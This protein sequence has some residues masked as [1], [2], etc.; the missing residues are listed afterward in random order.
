MPLL[1]HFTDTLGYN[2]IQQEGQIRP[3]NRGKFGAGVYLT[4]LNPNQAETQDIAQHLYQGGAQ[5]RQHQGRLNHF[6]QVKIPANDP[7]LKYV[8]EHVYRFGNGEQAL[9]LGLYEVQS[10]GPCI[11]WQ[12]ILCNA[13]ASGL[14]VHAA[15]KLYRNSTTGRQQRAERLRNELKVFLQD[16]SARY[17]VN[18]SR[19]GNS[20]KVRCKNCQT[21][22]SREYD[23]GYIYADRIDRNELYSAILQHEWEHYQPY[24]FAAAVCTLAI[25]IYYYCW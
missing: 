13:V 5:R 3:S 25:A 14:A 4:D 17:V 19:G 21:V 6:L 8:R 7:Y 20:C 16:A 24:V 1:F 9:D 10:Q 2:G 11:E 23:G 22:V 18:M 12:S 15:Q